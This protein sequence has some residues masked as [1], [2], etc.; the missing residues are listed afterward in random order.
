M[1]GTIPLSAA[2]GTASD[3]PHRHQIEGAPER[4]PEGDNTSQL[5]RLRE[6]LYAPSDGHGGGVRRTQRVRETLPRVDS[7]KPA[8]RNARRRGGLRVS[9]M[10]EE[11][12]EKKKP[13]RTPEDPYRGKAA[14]LLAVWQKLQRESQADSTR[15][16][17]HR[18]ET[19]RV[20]HLPEKLQSTGDVAEAPENPRGREKP[21][22]GFVG[23]EDFGQRETP[24]LRHHRKKLQPRSVK[25]EANAAGPSACDRNGAPRFLSLNKTVVQ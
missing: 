20:S 15:K 2:G 5:S 8:S 13:R 1:R 3:D 14:Q 17:P 4:L 12:P 21:Y 24:L 16:S 10:P 23:G 18:G 19:V 11:I 25:L 7:A 6:K 22:Q 9:F